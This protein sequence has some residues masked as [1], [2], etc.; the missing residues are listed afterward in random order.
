MSRVRTAAKGVSRTASGDLDRLALLGLRGSMVEL[1]S[2]L[3]VHPG[4]MVHLRGLERLFGER[5]GSL[6]RDLRALVALGALQRVPSGRQVNYMADPAWL[7]WSAIRSILCELADPTAL[8]REAL[9]GVPGVEAAFVYG[10]RAKGTARMN[11]DV[12]L[13]VLGDAVDI[14]ALH[15]SLAEVEFITDRQVNPG[16]YT[17]MKLAERLGSAGSPSRRFLSDILGGPKT[18]IAGAKDALRPI[19]AAADVRLAS[20]DG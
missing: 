9:R 12:D 6:Q 19:A 2:Y 15:R 1:L 17:R 18:W 10:S 16:V 4:T 3:M 20:T 7:L 11:S 14:K 13:F 5:S 8:V